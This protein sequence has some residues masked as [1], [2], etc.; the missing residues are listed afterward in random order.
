[1]PIPAFVSTPG[2][3]IYLKSRGFSLLLDG[4]T[5]SSRNPIQLFQSKPSSFNSNPNHRKKRQA[6]SPKPKPSTSGIDNFSLQQ[7]APLY[8][9]DISEKSWSQSNCCLSVLFLI[10][11]N[12]P[13]LS[14]FSLRSAFCFYFFQLLDFG[15]N[16]FSWIYSFVCPFS[17]P[18][19]Q[20]VLA[21]QERNDTYND[22][23]LNYIIMSLKET[24]LYWCWYR[25]PLYNCNLFCG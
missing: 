22:T 25:H 8:P 20:R 3:S 7:L 21:R 1:M 24:I 13:S 6:A 19:L 16:T 10:Q 4:G 12:I 2:A 15:C 14:F 11:P 23:L 5:A 17:N 18:I 9:K